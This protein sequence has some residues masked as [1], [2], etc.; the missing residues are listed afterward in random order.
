P[1]Y[2]ERD[3]QQLPA[4]L[5]AFLDEGDPPIA[6]TPGSA[7]F[8]GEAFFKAAV[9]ACQRLGRR[10][11][12]LT[13]H[14][15]HLPSDLPTGV[16]H[17]AFAPFS[18]LLPRCAAVVHHGG[19]GTLSQGFAAGIPQ[20]V[21]PMAHDQPDNARRLIDLG[22][23]GAIVPKRFKPGRLATLLK[24]LLNDPAVADR[25]RSLATKVTAHDGLA[26][27]ADEVEATVSSAGV[28]TDGLEATLG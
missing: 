15:D 6:F 13:R 16:R 23:G 9:E 11:L 7:M 25:C 5:A 28:A 8:F 12:L 4:D 14:A 27:A 17:V 22:V 19:I 26:R 3:T 20:I 10:G 18:G 1:L 2:D 24:R 21:M